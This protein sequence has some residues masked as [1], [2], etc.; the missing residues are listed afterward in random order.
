MIAALRG[1][2][3]ERQPTRILIDVQ[4][5]GYEV[6]IPLSTFDRLQADGEEI[7]LLTY[8][9]VREDALQ[10]YG[11]AT[12]AE[13]ELFLKLIGVSG[14]GPRVA[15]G[16]LSGC[17]VEE[18]HHLIRHGDIQRLT[19]LPGIGR[20]TAERL[21]LELKDKL[22]APIAEEPRGTMVPPGSEKEEAILAL[23]S[24]G[25]TRSQAEQA[26]MKLT[27]DGEAKDVETLIRLALQQL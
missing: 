14:I 5:V 13:K 10:L 23:T 24:L 8:L 19:S 27:A 17:R 12:E 18:F 9:H 2:L 1:K 22:E 15:L 3:I 21:V 20:K 4:G 25:Y 7:S 11:F 26:V 6:A 16:V